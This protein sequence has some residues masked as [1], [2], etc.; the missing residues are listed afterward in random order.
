MSKELERNLEKEA[1]ELEKDLEKEIPEKEKEQVLE[2]K[3]HARVREEKSVEELVSRVR[4]QREI[5][6]LDKE[7]PVGAKIH[8]KVN[9]KNLD[10]ER[11]DT[12]IRYKLD[13]KEVPKEIIEKMYNPHNEYEQLRVQ[14]MS[15]QQERIRQEEEKKKEKNIVRDD[16]VAW[17][18]AKST[19][20]RHEEITENI[21]SPGEGSAR[22]DDE[23]EFAD[24]MKIA[25]QMGYDR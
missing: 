22:H 8:M 9:G 5:E 16:K 20:A 1:P 25:A 3:P 4:F 17:F 11:D 2:K 23:R 21:T 7:M 6:K 24:G 14:I 19:I 10:I 12:R 18:D 13:G 15:F